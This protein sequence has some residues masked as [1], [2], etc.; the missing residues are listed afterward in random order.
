[1]DDLRPGSHPCCVGDPPGKH[2]SCSMQVKQAA[3]NYSTVCTPVWSVLTSPVGTRWQQLQPHLLPHRVLGEPQGQIRAWVLVSDTWV[4]ALYLSA[5]LVLSLDRFK[6]RTGE[7]PK[8][9]PHISTLGESSSSPVKSRRVYLG[10][11]CVA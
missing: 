2:S 6:E 10:A 8:A 3:P 11:H 9:H 7:G 5:G 4:Q 1:M